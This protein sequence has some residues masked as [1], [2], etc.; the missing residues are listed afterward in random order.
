MSDYKQVNDIAMRIKDLREIS[1]YTVE[2]MAEILNISVTDYKKLE[3]G[4]VDFPISYLLKVSET[5]KVDTTELLTGKSPHMNVYTITR[6]GQGHDIVRH[7]HYVYKNLAFNFQNR[8]VEPL[9]VTVPP[10]TNR[11]MRPNSHEGQEFDYI[12][13]GTMRIVIGEN[14]L[15]LRPGD[16]VYY[17]SLH[18]H[19]MQAIGDEPVN[20]LAIVIP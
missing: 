3:N 20:F 12:L 5:F 8:K 13:S 18:P 4:E 9:F 1:D 16:S 2:Q 10:N 19:A 17:D 7:D 6:N 15:I 14:E 11:K